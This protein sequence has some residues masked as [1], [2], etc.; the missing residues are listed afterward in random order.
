MRLAPFCFALLLLAAPAKAQDAA[1]GGA[2]VGADAGAFLGAAFS[3]M[4]YYHDGH[5]A[6]MGGLAGSVLGT[7]ALVPI[8]NAPE[9]SLATARSAQPPVAIRI[10]CRNITDTMEVDGAKVEVKGLVC[11]QPDGTW[12]VSP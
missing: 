11:K 8:G 12:K 7:L 5:G 4:P 10:D 1:L 6:M 9:P 2:A 3:N